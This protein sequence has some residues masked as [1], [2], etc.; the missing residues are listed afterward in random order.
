MTTHQTLVLGDDG[1]ISADLAWLWINCHEWP[2]W[3]LEVVTA[4]ATTDFRLDSDRIQLHP[5]H[6]T[7]PRQPFTESRIKEVTSLTCEMDPR[8][9]L[10]RATDL[11][12]VGRRGPGLAKAMH[13]GSTAE[14]LMAHPPAP[15][16]IARH[17]RRTLTAVVC[18][19]GSPHAAAAARSLAAMPW[20][21]SVAI[22]VV[23]I[24]DGTVDVEQA[25]SDVAG[26]FAATD[27]QVRRRTE[28]G[29]P[30][31]ELLVIL[32]DEH[33]DLVVLGTRG[34]TGIHRMRVGSTAGVIAHAVESSVLLACDET[35]ADPGSAG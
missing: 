19:D 22:T 28:Q 20:I 3:R 23:A 12:V 26:L 29:E 16:L 9:A 33:P 1:S 17:G 10:S 14:W 2:D 27:A 31:H 18:A 24:D 35:V 15:M 34:L 21:S 13:L 11:L 8:L 32:E 7:N 25:M 6:P 4:E 5:W 30:T